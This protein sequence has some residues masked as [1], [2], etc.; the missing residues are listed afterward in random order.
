MGIY[1]A[2]LLVIIAMG[3][4]IQ[5]DKSR[6]AKKWY[7]ILVFAIITVMAAL[8]S[9]SV[10]VDTA[11]FCRSYTTIGV[12]SWEYADV[13][14]YELG[15]YVL[16]K[17]LNYISSDP[18]LLL[19]ASSLLVYP[20][21]AF[22]IY[23]NSNNV[24]GSVFLFCTLVLF[25]SYMNVMRQ[26]IAIAIVLL[27]FEVCLK[28]DRRILFVLGVILA[29]L[30]HQSALLCLILIPLHKTRFTR[31]SLLIYGLIFVAAII[32]YRQFF[33]VFSW[34]LGSYSGYISSQYA[35]SNYFGALIRDVFYIF[36]FLICISIL[37][38]VQKEKAILSARNRNTDFFMHMA[39][40]T[41]I[42][43]TFGMQMEILARAGLY[44]SIFYVLLIPEAISALENKR[45][46]MVSYYFLY[47]STLLYFIVISIFRPEWYGAIPYSAFWM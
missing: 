11:M 12:M 45:I 30:F 24:V 25:F 7:V 6:A 46:K 20:S 8:R 31:R 22:F 21:A 4:I 35:V 23:R 43:L 28:K 17:L 26:A 47:L 32:F 15:F 27:S 16:C 29:S 34:I 19:I 3:A 38:P 18:Q 33:N 36:L 13:S 41:I 9:S 40:L 39:A 5:P 2:L 44:F 42:C 1:L 14:R 10:G 37:I